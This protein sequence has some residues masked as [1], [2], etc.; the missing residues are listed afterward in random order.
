MTAG[1]QHLVFR[2]ATMMRGCLVLL[3]YEKTTSMSITGAEEAA[4][5]TLMSTDIERIVNGMSKIHE[6]WS[7]LLQMAVALALL[8][9]QLGVVFI[10]PLVLFLSE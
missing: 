9:R 3:I 6:S 1:C 4:A 5:V 2:Y 7:T 8:Y 10:V